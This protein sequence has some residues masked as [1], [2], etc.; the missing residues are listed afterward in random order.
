M[1]LHNRDKHHNLRVTHCAEWERSNVVIA[2]AGKCLFDKTA[3]HLTAFRMTVDRF[4]SH[5]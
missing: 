5:L 3:G 2:V 1:V 4:C